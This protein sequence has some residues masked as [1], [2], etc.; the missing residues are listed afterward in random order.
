MTAFPSWFPFSLILQIALF[1]FSA[2]TAKRPGRFS[3]RT[4][5]TA[6]SKTRAAFWIGFSL[7]LASHC[8]A[9]TEVC[10]VLWLMGVT[11]GVFGALIFEAMTKLVNVVGTINPGNFGTFEGGNMLIG[12]TFGLTGATGLALALARRLRALFWTAVGGICL[13]ILTRSRS[14]G[15]AERHRN[16]LDD[17]A[18]KNTGAPADPPL[19]VAA[20]GKFTVAIL[21][22]EGRP[23]NG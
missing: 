10:L 15:N 3:I 17:I 19:G 1:P 5:S 16:M 2:L 7:N 4:K 20:E 6:N 18:G 9:V 11:F 23:G 12:K 13:F 21:L 22:T 8:M 14:H